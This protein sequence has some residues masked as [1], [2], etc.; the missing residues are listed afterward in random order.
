MAAEH[1]LVVGAGQ[2]GAGIA[3]VALT[4][5]NQVTLVDSAKAAVEKGQERVRTGLIKL[6]E[7]GKLDEEQHK[8]ALS[9]LTLATSISEAK[10]VDFGIEAVVESEE[11]K[12]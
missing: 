12:R 8:L 11:V 1:V 7:K 4:S 6:K 10:D 3:Q 5:G 2:M 9:R